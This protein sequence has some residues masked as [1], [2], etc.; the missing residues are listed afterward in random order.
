MIKLQKILE[1]LTL[2][3]MEQ[4]E[5]GEAY[6]GIIVEKANFLDDLGADSID[7]IKIIMSAEEEFNVSISDAELE[8]I[9]TVGDLAKFVISAIDPKKDVAAAIANYASQINNLSVQENIKLLADKSAELLPQLK[10]TWE[11]TTKL[12]FWLEECLNFKILNQTYWG[13]KT[14]GDLLDAVRPDIKKLSPKLPYQEP[15][16]RGALMRHFVSA[17]APGAR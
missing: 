7:I 17:P 8:K 1:R 2:I 11:E 9:D 6:K 12:I 13:I 15:S 10:I 3:I 5:L 4:L 14:V 16:M